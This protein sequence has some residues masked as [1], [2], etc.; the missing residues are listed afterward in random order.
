MDSYCFSDSLKKLAE[1]TNRKTFALFL[2]ERNISNTNKFI[3]IMKKLLL[4]A[5]VLITATS[6]L[7]RSHDFVVNGITYYLNKDGKSVTVTQKRGSYSGEVII[8]KEIKYLNANLVVTSIDDL[9]FYQCS[10]LTSVTIPNSVK[11]IGSSAFKSCPGL[12]S[13]SIPDSVK[14]IGSNAF[15]SCPGLTSVSI[16][17]SVKSIGSEAFSNC[18]G[19]TSVTI[20]DSV[21]NIGGGA[22]YNCI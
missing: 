16:P 9:A 7:A 19:I 20:P 17:N 13:V 1:I 11:S 10:N 14:S 6:A 22:F 3:L 18:S 4:L 2:N 12:T 5:L 15:S 8:P 21:S